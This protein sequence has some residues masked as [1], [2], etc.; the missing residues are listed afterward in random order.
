[1]FQNVL[2]HHISSWFS[3]WLECTKFICNTTR[4]LVF[5]TILCS[6]FVVVPLASFH[7]AWFCNNV[8]AAILQSPI[9]LHANPSALF[10][11][12][13]NVFLARSLRTQG[14]SLICTSLCFILPSL[15]QSS[16]I[17]STVL[18]ITP[19]S[20]VAIQ[21][22]RIIKCF[23]WF[24]SAPSKF[25]KIMYRMIYKGNSLELHVCLWA[26]RNIT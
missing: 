7:F 4:L 9:C 23:G 26:W 21:R 13:Q 19:T 1:M 3:I 18:G 15:L 12:T 25:V 17:W 5:E 8:L 6:F 11:L 2:P 20:I 24:T 10:S 16:N 14:V 22:C